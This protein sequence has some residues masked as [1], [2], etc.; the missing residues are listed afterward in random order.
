MILRTI[1]SVSWSQD[2]IHLIALK[3]LGNAIKHHQVSQSLKQM[4]LT[5]IGFIRY[6][7]FPIFYNGSDVSP[8][9]STQNH[10]DDLHDYSESLLN[11]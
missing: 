5:P 7:D 10:L 8:T 1:Q 4:D 11:L 3:Q 6:D 2:A 9:T